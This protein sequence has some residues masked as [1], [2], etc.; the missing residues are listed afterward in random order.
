[1][2][3]VL[4]NDTKT[5]C[6]KNEVI[7]ID[8][9]D[10]RNELL[11]KIDQYLTQAGDRKLLLQLTSEPLCSLENNELEAIADVLEDY[12]EEMQGGN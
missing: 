11:S 3:L 8:K 1:M 12:L 9:E 10:K 4:Q 7:D 6:K 2:N 5:Y